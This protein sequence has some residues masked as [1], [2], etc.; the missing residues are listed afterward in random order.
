GNTLAALGVAAFGLISILI[1]TLI[2]PVFISKFAKVNTSVIL[3]GIIGGMMVFGLFGI[4]LGPL[5]LSY[6]VIILEVYR[7]KKT[8]EV[9]I[10]KPE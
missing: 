3:I 7:D 9:F 2:K 10:Q 5:I 4:I 1:E 6:L 8:P